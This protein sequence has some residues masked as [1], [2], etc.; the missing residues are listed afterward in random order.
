MCLNLSNKSRLFISFFMYYFEI[1]NSNPL[2][3]A[4]KKKKKGKNCIF[5]FLENIANHLSIDFEPE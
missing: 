3:I 1:Q 5:F 2:N 4:Q